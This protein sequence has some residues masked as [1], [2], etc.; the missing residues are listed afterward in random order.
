MSSPLLH[1]VV[2]VQLLMQALI[3]VAPGR[4]VCMPLAT[5]TTE[6]CAVRCDDRAPLSPKA[7]CC[8]DHRGTADRLD[9]GA[10]GPCHEHRPTPLHLSLP[11]AGRCGCHLHLPIPGDPQI[12]GPRMARIDPSAS[13]PAALPAL[14]GNDSRLMRSTAAREPLL[15]PPDAT[16]R[17]E[18]RSLRSVRLRL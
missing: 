2:I 12:P 14:D 16:R 8:R 1:F 4:V 9:P 15:D 13:L 11:D 18:A 17:S 7:S 5:C 3:G 10:A 6:R